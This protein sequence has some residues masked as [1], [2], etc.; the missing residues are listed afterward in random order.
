MADI[1][2]V[3]KYIAQQV[4]N[5]VYPESNGS[6]YYFSILPAL[7]AG[8][9]GM[10]GVITAPSIAPAAPGQTVPMDV[11]IYE[12]WPV[13][14][15]L[16]LDMAG[17]VESTTSPQSPPAQRANGPRCHV[18][19]FPIGMSTRA[20]YQIQD[21]TYVIA[22]PVLGLTVVTDDEQI[23][24]T[25]TPNTGEIVTIIADRQHI[26]SSN[27]PTTA[28]ILADLLSQ[29]QLVYPDASLN[30]SV[31][32]VP[33]GYSMVVRQ[34]GVGTLGKVVRRQCHSVMVSIWAPDPNSRS[35]LAAAID[36]A[37]KEN[38]V[39]TL[40]DTSQAKIVYQRTN[41]S[42]E[43]ENV[44]IYRRD[45]VYD[46]EYATLETFPGTT[47]TSVTTTLNAFEY[48]PSP[49]PQANVEFIS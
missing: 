18:S 25:G 35:V 47:I 2:D 38:I 12:G 28:G 19:V 45:L 43:Q 40:P 14:E 29:A 22:P 27:R 42:D 21:N 36:V 46:V 24:I 16:W 17:E 10:G 44:T 3:T 13:P 20:P 7:F 8:F 33:F 23:T 1:S 41:I 31:L 37:L 6:A 26:F 49:N 11:L 34:G 9:G 30:G 48:G 32:T 4:A 39:V 15:L 5:A